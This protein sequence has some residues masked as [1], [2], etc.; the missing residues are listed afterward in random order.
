[1]I[2]LIIAVS[3]L[4][5]AWA[6]AGEYEVGGKEPLPAKMPMP[7]EDCVDL[8][9]EISVGYRTDYIVHGLR[10][11]QD[12]VWVDVNYTFSDLAVPL[13]FGA[14]HNSGINTIFPFGFVGPI[15]TTDV[16][17]VSEMEDVAGFD[18]S[19]GYR[20]RFLNFG[21]P[22]IGGMSYGE[23][24]FDLRKDLGFVDLLIGSTVG[25]DSMDSFFAAGGG[26]GWAHRI[27]LEKSL[28]LCDYADLILSGGVG[29]H[30]GFFFNGPGT[31]DWSHYYLQAALPVSLNCRTTVTPYIGYLGVQQWDVFSP[32]GD[33]L[34]GGVSISVTF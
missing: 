23:V 2:R 34:H 3:F 5:S 33:A 27:G 26:D 11:D 25:V 12:T 7:I 8:G 10:V 21:L 4:A 14:T 19:I 29:Y 30:D 15:D 31:R 18:L 6:V 20:H 16:Y 32:Q 13:T 24:S 9:G 28:P 17:L 1:M 22:V